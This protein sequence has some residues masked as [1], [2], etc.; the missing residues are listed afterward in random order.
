[1]RLPPLLSGVFAW[2]M[3]VI[4]TPI[5]ADDWIHWRGPE[6]DGHSLE[7]NLPETFSPR[8]GG[9]NLI[10]KQPIEGRS[11][12]LVMNGRVYVAG[13]YD[14]SLP[15]EG[16]RVVCMDEATGKILW[17]KRFNVFH[18]NIVSSRLGWTTLTG[19]PEKD[20]VY[21]HSTAGL[22]LCYDKEGNLVWSHSLTE[23]Y[24]RVSGYGGRNVSPIFDSGLC[25]VGF[26]NS[27]WGGQA[28]PANRF[29]A[30][31]GGTGEVVWWA[32]TPYSI[33]GTYY[34][35]P[36]IAVVNGQRLMVAGGADGYVHAFKV[37]TGERVWSYQFSDGVVNPSPVVD[38]NYMWICHG[39]ENPEGGPLGRI[40]CLDMA[41]M[42]NDKP[43]L[44]WEK[45]YGK[46]YGLASPALADGRLYVPD[47]AADLFCLNAKTGKLL[48]REKFG[49]VARGAAL[50]ADDKLYIFDV[51][52]MMKIYG[53]N[54]DDSPDELD[55]IPFRRAV[56]TS[57]VECNGTPIAVNG[58]LYFITQDG[59]YCVGLPDAKPTN[60]NYKPMP[61]EAP[62][63]LNA[64]PSSIRLFPA[65][66]LMHKSGR[67]EFK[68]IPMDANGRMLTKPEETE[69]KWSLPDPAKLPSGMQPKGLA[70]ATDATGMMA[71]LTVSP[72]PR[73]QGE[74][75][76]TAGDMK[77]TAR[78]R[79]A[80]QPEDMY[81]EDFEKLPVGAGIA[82][83]INAT[84]SKFIVVEMDGGKVLKKT[85]DSP[86]P[87]LA[88]A[89]GYI[90]GP[91]AHD[92]TI[93]A[94]VYAEE[95]RGKTAEMGLIN[96]RYTLTMDGK[97]DAEGKRRVH[98]TSWD[99]RPRLD[100]VKTYDWQPNT[101]YHI[102]FRIENATGMAMCKVYPK[103]EQEP[104]DWLIKF[105]DPSPNPSGAA[106][107]YGYTPNA[108]DSVPGAAAYLDNVRIT[109]NK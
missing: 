70:G 109:P 77:A 66:V 31:D 79:V 7:T 29:V 36:V 101:W 63:D 104:T 105:T 60:P 72:L 83:W 84:S 74:I 35:N 23:E 52:A 100:E 49:T 53:L 28:R 26:V 81:T 27:S 12:P 93:E 34:S 6:Q 50:I 10:W 16:E 89:D 20:Y 61:E 22:M 39:E 98:I 76:V 91:D 96:S 69:M 33:S 102:K 64:K 56:G 106:G 51:L 99:A 86:K 71:Q 8:E 3:L 9:T 87:P 62:F 17:E 68:V 85:N 4:A 32:E 107:V 90:T 48:W 108:T 5:Q 97:P 57:I 82:G 38:G 40:I 65:D 25:I 67:E 19:D 73:Q 44:V 88:R 37:R 94:D 78:V 24:G 92:Y 14:A 59:T 1:M 95:V 54:G 2:A 47:D 45:I 30:F 43:T 13:G 11:A 18:T 42:T 103:G 80:T 41:K 55:R 58:R 21:F 75:M 46:R 15:T